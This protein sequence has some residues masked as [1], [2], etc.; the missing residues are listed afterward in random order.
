MLKKFTNLSIA[1]KVYIPL[2]FS[3]VVGAVVVIAMFYKSLLSVEKEVKLTQQK[4]MGTVLQMKLNEKEQIGLTNAINLSYN[5]Y[6]IDALQEN[7]RTV[8][9]EGLHEVSSTFKSATQYKNIK[10]HIHT[11]DI[12]SFVRLW[13]LKKYGDDLS[14]FR[15]TIKHVATTKQPLGAF[16]V[17]R[18]GLVI[19]GL[20][21]VFDEKRQRYLGSVEFIQGLNSV[22]RSLKSKGMVYVT[23]MDN[24]YLHI[25]TKLKNAPLLFKRY[26]LA[27][28]QGAYDE[29]FVADLQSVASLSD[30]F[31]AGR[32][33]VIAQPLKDFSGKII[34]YGLIGKPLSA[35]DDLV[36]TATSSLIQQA[37]IMGVI[38]ILMLVLLVFIVSRW[39]ITPLDELK[40]KVADL[41][42]GD[43]DLTK[44]IVVASED[45]LGQ[46][47]QH[48][49]SFIDK[50]HGIITNIKG[51]TD[52]AVQAAQGVKN[53][54]NMMLSGVEKQNRLIS[55]AHEVTEKI[56]NE[57]ELSL[58]ST[59]IAVEDILNTQK[60]LDNTAQY[61]KQIVQEVTSQAE[62][63][64]DIA[65]RIN[66]L[67]EQTTQIKAVIDII[68]DIAD[69][70]NLLALNAA[71]EAARAGEH[72]RGFAVVADEVRKLAERTQKSLSEIDASVSIIVQ[73]VIEAQGEIEKGVSQAHK[74]SS[75]TQEL[76]EDIGATQGD[77]KEAVERI[78]SASKEA[79]IIKQSIE[80][81]EAINDGLL[82]ESKSTYDESQDL[83]SVS[84]R[85]K[86]IA[87]KLQ[88]EVDKFKV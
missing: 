39:V 31:I 18:A 84:Q 61:L 47:A 87:L 35:I 45:E 60:S 70:T 12:H 5:K 23:I 27:T 32:Y 54:S 22:S 55:N 69:Q 21:P 44:K 75:V 34:G 57:S 53:N 52:N 49:N 71:I 76:S 4:A 30:H 38:N 15:H 41:A 79:K 1:K 46:V 33:Y 62:H 86:D 77:L 72:G 8:A 40:D 51:S 73:G 48:I 26:K 14:S 29:R 6:I 16:E 25:A 3:L 50:L 20:A 56:K 88:E 65:G 85:L 10:I 63:E 78:V 80:D 17:G 19:R 58:E 43:G 37:T 81:L 9:I 36:D 83:E 74:V 66:A 42:H 7:N 82:D 68:K 67:V 28:K 64:Q 11:A 13:N 24:K 2:M 59:N